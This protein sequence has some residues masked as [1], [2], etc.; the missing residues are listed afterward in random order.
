MHSTSTLESAT[1][2]V[3]EGSEFAYQV[4]GRKTPITP[5]SIYGI[6]RNYPKHI[7]ELSNQRPEEPV[8]FLKSQASLRPFGLPDLKSSSDYPFR[9]QGL[10]HEAEILVL[11]GKTIPLG[12]EPT[13]AHI[14][15]LGLGL[16][17]T[18]RAVQDQ[19]KSKGL[20]WARAKNFAGSAMVSSFVPVTSE[21]DLTQLAF[22]FLVNDTLRQVGQSRMM[23][24]PILQL[25][26]S[27]AMLHPLVPGD[28][29]FTGTPEG[30]GP[31]KPGDLLTLEWTMPWQLQWTQIF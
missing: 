14:G 15:G 22:R 28:L 29:I 20:P 4:L 24:W 26:K 5:R 8:V 6:G 27:L 3:L 2:P 7:E 13:P 23:I 17:L 18:R 12:S 25:L 11:I 10:H 16:D 19:L 9:D 21:V 1:Q 31:L 30:V